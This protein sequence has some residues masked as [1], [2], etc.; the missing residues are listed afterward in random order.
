MF[1]RTVWLCISIKSSNITQAC[2]EC[3]TRHC[4]KFKYGLVIYPFIASTVSDASN[5]TYSETL[6]EIFFAVF[7]KKK[8]VIHSGA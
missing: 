3:M 5:T 7:R 1:G 4:L 6:A 8:S 2:D